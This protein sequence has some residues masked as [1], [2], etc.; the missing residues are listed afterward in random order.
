MTEPAV[1]TCI[2]GS[3]DEAG[4]LY[5]VKESCYRLLKKLLDLWLSS[6]FERKVLKGSK[7]LPDLEIKVSNLA[8]QMISSAQP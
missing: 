7:K 3:C 2:T 1:S 6:F 5:Q 8:T 4:E